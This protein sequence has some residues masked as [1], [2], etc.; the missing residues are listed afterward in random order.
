LGGRFDGPG[1]AVVVVV[2][3]GRDDCF[4][5]VFFAAGADEFVLGKMEGLEHGLG[6]IGEGACGA[7]LDVT[8]SDGDEDTAE[9][10]VEVVGGE[11]VAGEEEIEIFTDFLIGA[12]LSFF[13]GVVETEVGTGG[14]AGS[15]ATA[16]VV[17]SETT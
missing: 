11:I 7:G 9:G 4:A 15:A 16:A 13:L 1:E 17:E 10:G 14:D 2:V 3:D 12:G 5:P 6:E 8:A